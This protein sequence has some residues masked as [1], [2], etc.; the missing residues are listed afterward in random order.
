M[1][2]SCERKILGGDLTLGH[3]AQDGA[4]LDARMRGAGGVVEA[5][6]VQE[7]DADV[8]V[9]VCLLKVPPQ[10]RSLLVD[11]D[12]VLLTKA[13]A[14]VTAHRRRDPLPRSLNMSALALNACGF[15]AA[16]TGVAMGEGLRGDTHP[17]PVH[18]SR[19]ANEKL[20]CVVTCAGRGS[21]RRPARHHEAQVGQHVPKP[22]QRQGLEG[23]H[24]ELHPARTPPCSAVMEEASQSAV[25]ACGAAQSDAERCRWEE[26]GAC[27][28]T[29]LY[30]S[31]Y[32]RISSGSCPHR[33]MSATNRQGLRH[34]RN[35]CML[36]QSRGRG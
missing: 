10:R 6:E 4:Q 35:L 29:C 19:Q 23:R 9:G 34:T 3:G 33:G 21:M 32:C 25:G 11:R 14:P 16:G 7:D 27:G 8:I 26:G 13:W 15:L 18:M 36:L 20:R 2:R 1:I 17:D 22:P 28:C 31:W 5:H 24:E 30:V 12:A